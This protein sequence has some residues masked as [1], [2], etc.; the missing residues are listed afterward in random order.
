MGR[1]NMC[2]CTKPYYN[3]LTLYHAE[4]VGFHLEMPEI[5]SR[6]RCYDSQTLLT[7]LHYQSLPISSLTKTHIER[8][9]NNNNKKNSYVAVDDFRS[10]FF[11]I[12]SNSR[13]HESSLDSLR[14]AFSIIQPHELKNNNIMGN[15]YQHRSFEEGTYLRNQ[16]IQ[17]KS[18]L[19]VYRNFTLL[20]LSRQLS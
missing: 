4:I 2:E 7:T 18:L 15:A 1:Y 9:N 11:H 10:P 13:Q 14:A 8:N 20:C 12:F 5:V 16:T 3:L 19:T 17:N 6:L